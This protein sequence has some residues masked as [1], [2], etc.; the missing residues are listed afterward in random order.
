MELFFRR[1]PDI[2]KPTVFIAFI[3]RIRCCAIT[4]PC[5]A[6]RLAQLAVLNCIPDCNTASLY[7]G[8]VKYLGKHVCLV[9]LCTLAASCILSGSAHPL[10]CQTNSSRVSG[11][12]DADRMVKDWDQTETQSL[13]HREEGSLSTSSS[14]STL[15][16]L[17]PPSPPATQKF[18]WRPVLVILA[19]NTV[20]PL[21]FELVFPFV[22][23]CPFVLMQLMGDR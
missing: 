19:L 2:A 8:N 13:L 9:W 17:S 6:T 10:P 11:S 20:V 15:Y 16:S 23:M 18:P 21:A 5:Q 22:S 7:G 14:S 4:R 3:S 12:S 1:I